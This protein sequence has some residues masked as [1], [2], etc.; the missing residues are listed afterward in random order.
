MILFATV[1]VVT[2]EIVRT[3]THMSPVWPIYNTLIHLDFEKDN[4]AFK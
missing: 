3:L 2:D 1:K 4:Q